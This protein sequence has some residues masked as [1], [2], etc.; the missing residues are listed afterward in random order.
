MLEQKTFRDWRKERGYTTKY[1]AGVL[2]ISPTA[3]TARERR[4]RGFSKLEQKI[5]CEL[6]NIR[7][8]Q[9]LRE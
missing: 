7:I 2:E 6:Y 8:E 4:G 9:V 5:L 3:L 1:V